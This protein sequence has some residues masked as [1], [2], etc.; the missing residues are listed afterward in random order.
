M[1]IDTSAILAWLKHEAE[2]ERIVAALERN[3]TCRIS[4][5]SVL[6][7][8]IVVS[9]PRAPGHDRQ[10]AAIFKGDRGRDRSL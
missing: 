1:V 10:I 6:E 4:A 9:A 2:R 3:T 8:H 7:A 5:I